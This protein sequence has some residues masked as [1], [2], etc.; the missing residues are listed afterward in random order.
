[1]AENSDAVYFC[2]R[3]AL[4][5]AE[6]EIRSDLAIHKMFTIKY[7]KNSIAKAYISKKQEL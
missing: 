1:M 2:F 3:L 7:H 4:T 6:P 5:A